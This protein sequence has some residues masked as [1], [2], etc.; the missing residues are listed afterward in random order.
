VLTLLKSKA[1]APTWIVGCCA[2]ALALGV[3][4]F[5]SHAGADD[6][7]WVLAPSAWLARFLGG[8]DLVYERGAGFISHAHH[9]VVGPPCAGVNF[10]VICFLCVYFSFASYFPAKAKWFLVS[11]GIAFGGTIAANSLRIFVSAHL[12]DA[13]FYRGWLTQEDMHRVAGIA[14]Y[15]ASLLALYVAVESRIRARGH[16]LAPLAW[17]VAISLGVPLAGRV[18]AGGAP[19]FSGHALWVLGVALL[20]T[21]VK[22]LP[23]TVR[24]RIHF[25][26]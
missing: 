9:M 8:I 25:R 26:A 1:T 4:A 11:L 13:E 15:Y 18:I 21:L 19:G 22:A 7:L 6:L 17:Y 24:N 10:L 2:I 16:R 5:Y 12:W 14:I 23:S 3:K 20:L